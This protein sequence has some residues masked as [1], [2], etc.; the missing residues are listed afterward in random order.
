MAELELRRGVHAEVDVSGV[1]SAAIQLVGVFFG[2]L[3]FDAEGRASIGLSAQV[4]LDL[5]D[6]CGFVVSAHAGASA[7]AS[8]RAEAGLSGK[9][10]RKA[11]GDSVDGPW[12]EMAEGILPLINVRRVQPAKLGADSCDQGQS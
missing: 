1:L 10:L 11:A 12:V 2:R 3:S 9:A 6:R 4:P 8:V 7:A 5:F